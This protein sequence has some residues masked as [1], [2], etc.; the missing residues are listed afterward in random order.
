MPIMN[1][2]I[3]ILDTNIILSYA[4]DFEENHVDCQ[5]YFSLDI[6]KTTC[7]RVN[8]ELGRISS[9]RNK[10][11]EDIKRFLET[12]SSIE[13]YTPSIPLNDN[14]IKHVKKI[15]PF[16]MKVPM[17]NIRQYLDRKI[18]EIQSGINNARNMLKKPFIGLYNHIALE[19]HIDKWI[20]NMSDS[21]ILSDSCCWARE[22]KSNFILSTNDYSD[23]INK[24]EDLYYCICGYYENDYKDKNFEILS[25]SEILHK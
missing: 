21:Q 24:R 9:K 11:Y 12:I 3:H 15:M 2:A 17:Y 1:N 8:I 4:S 13:K 25:V 7:S 20:N 19:T 23:F 18:R 10:L 5:T 16:L 22:T 14:E 6:I